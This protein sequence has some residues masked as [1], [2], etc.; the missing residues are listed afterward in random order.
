MSKKEEKPSEPTAEGHLAPQ[1]GSDTVDLVK[2]KYDMRRLSKINELDKIWI[3]FF[4]M[5][6]DM[7]G[8]SFTN[9]FCDNYLNLAVS[10]EGWRVNKMIQAI[11]GSK[12]AT[13]VGELVKRPGLLQRNIT[14]RDWKK[15]ADEEGK[16]VVE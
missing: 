13:S 9:E 15:K 8:G 3:A 2:G 5:V 1:F 4:R 6:P 12:G 14:Q 11:A 10:E 16:T 7:E